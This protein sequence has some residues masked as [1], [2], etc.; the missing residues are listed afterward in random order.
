MLSC[1]KRLLLFF[2]SN[3]VTRESWE[4]FSRHKNINP[5]LPCHLNHPAMALPFS[6]KYFI[7]L[8]LCALCWIFVLVDIFLPSHDALS[9]HGIHPRKVKGLIGIFLAPI[10]NVDAYWM[11][12]NTVGILIFGWLLLRRFVIVYPFENESSKENI[13]L[14]FS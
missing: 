7:P 12:T 11:I 10:M 14:K 8:V 6:G 5:F 2:V 3:F 9:S 1:K 4:E 13:F